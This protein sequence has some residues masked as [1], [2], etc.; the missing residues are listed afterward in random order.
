MY[1]QLKNQVPIKNYLT[2]YS[3]TGFRI[4]SEEITE[5]YAVKRKPEGT[6]KWLKIGAVARRSGIGIE[7][8]RF[9]EKQ[10]LQPPAT[11]PRRVSPVRQA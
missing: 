7:T 11:L 10:G 2:L 5:M 1:H 4:D 3:T 9:Y 8:L 6:A